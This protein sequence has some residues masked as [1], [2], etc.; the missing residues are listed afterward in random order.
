MLNGRFLKIKAR[1]YW[2]CNNTNTFHRVHDAQFKISW[3]NVR[4][5]ENRYNNSGALFSVWAMVFERNVEPISSTGGVLESSL[6]C[7]I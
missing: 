6:R 4:S 1:V 7:R 3:R 5:E 2:Q